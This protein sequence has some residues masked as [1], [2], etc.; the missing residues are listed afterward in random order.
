MHVLYFLEDRAQEGFIKALVERI[1]REESI[2][3]G[4]LIHDIRS[5]SGG[6]RVI[7][8]FKNFLKDTNKKMPF[9]IDFL[10]VAVDGNCKGYKDRI[11]ELEK[12]IKPNHPLQNRIIYAIPDP[13]I[14]RWYIIDQRAIKEG[15]GL[16]KGPDLPAY[17]CR[18]NYYK[19][20]LRQA[21]RGSN[22]SSLLG[23][24]E[25]AEKI[26]ESIKDLD[27]LGKE[28]SGFQTFVQGLRRVFKEKSK[29]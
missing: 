6:Y 28:N 27:A 12:Y 5:A 14:E 24:V 22:I 16:N 26:V 4:S 2:T 3:A 7:Q 8:A 21:L 23:G 18:K 11:K 17:K 15:V 20:I 9:D 19:Q 29:A 25:Y 1:A 10:V 13:H